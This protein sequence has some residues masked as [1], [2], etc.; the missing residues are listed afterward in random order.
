MLPPYVDRLVRWDAHWYTYV[1]ETGYDQ[2]SIV[3]FPA[4]ILLIRLIAGLGCGYVYAGLTLC[5]IFALL[6]FV[7]LYALLRLEYP[8][9]T[10]RRALVAYAVMPTS[11][12]LNSI[13]TESLFLTFTFASLYYARNDKMLPAGLFGAAAALTRNLGGALAIALACEAWRS[14]R[15]RTPSAA[16]ML[17]PAMPVL[18][19]GGFMAFNHYL[20]GDPLAFVTLQQSWGRHFDWPVD[21][22]IA[23]L[24][25]M[26]RLTANTQAGIALDTFMVLLGLTALLKATLT[27]PPLVRPSYLVLGWLWLLVP[28]FS[29]SAFLPLY[30]LSRFLLVVF[31]IYVVFA[32]QPRSLFY[33]WAFVSILLLFLC[34][35]MFANWF[36]VG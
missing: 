24:G 16:H 1:A 9:H 13:Y 30:S 14:S 33:P 20:L 12:F 32:D 2:R 6:S 15:R 4:I 8:E 36:W 21:N 26:G 18:A 31:P 35:T 25:F 28:L 10:A 34:T 19:I 22:F 29:T 5:N 27:R 17:G 3:F 11:F 23:N 7:T